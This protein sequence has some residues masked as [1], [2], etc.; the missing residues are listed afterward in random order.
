[1]L[2]RPF[3]HV[4]HLLRMAGFAA[5]VLPEEVE[6]GV[7][8]TYEDLLARKDELLDMSAATEGWTWR[9]KMMAQQKAGQ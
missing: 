1:M 9:K 5:A 4:L 6:L 7:G 2:L 8:A 3:C